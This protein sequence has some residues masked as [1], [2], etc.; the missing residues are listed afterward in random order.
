M[1]LPQ[2][3]YSAGKNKNLNRLDCWQ[4]EIDGALEATEIKPQKMKLSEIDYQAKRE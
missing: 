3:R 2:F 4:S 1:S